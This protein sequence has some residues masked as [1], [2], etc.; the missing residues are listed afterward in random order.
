MA[1]AGSERYPGSD[2]VTGCG[3][4]LPGGALSPTSGGHC[5]CTERGAQH[6]E[7]C[8]R[9]LVSN[10]N[11]VVGGGDKMSVACALLIAEDCLGGLHRSWAA[12]LAC[13]YIRIFH[14]IGPIIMGQR[15]VVVASGLAVGSREE[16]AC[17]GVCREYRD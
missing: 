1:L 2:D 11:L 6:A 14:K 13:Q 5:T 3:T 8:C 4:P 12:S 16:Q 17:A 9:K 10:C 15:L 7:G